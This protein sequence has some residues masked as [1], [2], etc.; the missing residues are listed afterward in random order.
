MVDH[1]NKMTV[2]DE[3]PQFLDNPNHVVRNGSIPN[4][5]DGNDTDGEEQE[6]S[7]FNMEFGLLRRED[8]G[9]MYTI[10]MRHKLYYEARMLQS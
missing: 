7:Y 2:S 4:S 10:V 9:I 3:H 6:D 1:C 8:D 5:E